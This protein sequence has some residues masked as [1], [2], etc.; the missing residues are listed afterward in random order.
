MQGVQTPTLLTT[1]AL[2]RICSV[3]PKTIHNWVEA[4]KLTCCKTPGGHLRFVP[5]VVVR[6]LRQHGFDV[7]PEL[8]ALDGGVL[9]IGPEE[10][11]VAVERLG[12]DVRVRHAADAFDG[13]V[14][15]G[16]EPAAYYVVGPG[17]AP[18]RIVKYL[19]AL[20]RATP[21]ARLVLAGS[22]ESAQ[23]VHASLPPEVPAT[24]VDPD[25][26][27]ALRAALGLATE[28]GEAAAQA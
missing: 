2:A 6:F 11:R 5:L 20:L 13:L 1:T 8:A 18:A 26:Q 19:A 22:G 15:A 4:G 16:Q 17:V 7:P 10:L 23:A 14:F 3:D 9:V 28:E 25:D 21:W 27:G 24:W 12:S